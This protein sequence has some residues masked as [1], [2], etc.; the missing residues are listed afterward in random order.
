MDLEGYKK[1]YYDFNDVVEE[2]D[3]KWA[4]KYQSVIL[5]GEP[6]KLPNNKKM[7]TYMLLQ[8]ISRMDYNFLNRP[9]SWEDEDGRKHTGVYHPMD[10]LYQVV[11]QSN[12]SL[13]CKLYQK[14]SLCKLAVP[15]V[16]KK[17]KDF[18]ECIIT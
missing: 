2:D 12:I 18:Y 4:I 16:M 13:R 7:A 10:L 1:D 6:E 14:L 9:I 15:V 11:D 5:G 8:S 17:K 3:V